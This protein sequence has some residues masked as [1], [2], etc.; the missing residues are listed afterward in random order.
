MAANLVTPLA[1]KRWK[2]HRWIA[3]ALGAVGGGL[4]GFANT[5]Y[6]LT[7]GLPL[8]LTNEGL[9]ILLLVAVIAPL[10]EEHVKLLAL[11]L[12]R[13]EERATYTP[14][15]WMALG[16]L[17]GAGFGVAEAF[18][19]FQALIVLSPALAAYNLGLRAALTVPLHALTAA[20]TGYGF[21]LARM[22][23]NGWLL[24]RGLLL[25]ILIHSAYNTFQTLEVMG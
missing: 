12:L 5:A 10:V 13:A 16:A 21:G 7:L 20:V 19:Y 11:I 22:R 23:R 24:A 17:A 2:R 9:F 3:F 6:G 15:R 18:F 14:R 1:R 8:A 4:A 25:A